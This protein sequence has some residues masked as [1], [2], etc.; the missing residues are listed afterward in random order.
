ML[1]L[2]A[3]FETPDSGQI[4]LEGKAMAGIHPGQRPLSFV[5][6]D[7][8]LFAHLDVFTN[9]ALGI[10]PSLRLDGAQKL[11]VSAALDRVGLGGFEQRQPA[12]LSGGER[13]RVAFARALVR[14]RPILLLDEPFAALDPKLHLEMA[15]LLKDI[16]RSEG[17]TVVIVTHHAVDVDSLA[18][19][20]L[21]IEQGHNIASE[22]VDITQ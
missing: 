22:H 1:M 3:G 15:D 21:N 7:N 9:I 11:A 2:L 8:N 17:N 4:R 16:H 14:K 13:Q 18:D 20:V 6:Q 19:T 5:F 12:N 10:S